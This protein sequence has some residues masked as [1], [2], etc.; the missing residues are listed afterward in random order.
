MLRCL[1]HYTYVDIKSTYKLHCN[2]SCEQTK[3]LKINKYHIII[4]LY[5]EYLY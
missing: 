4:L 2:P 5:I 3:F 1:S